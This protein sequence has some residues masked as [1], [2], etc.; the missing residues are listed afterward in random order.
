[1]I[2]N[3]KLGFKMLRHGY[4]MVM[5]I[6]QAIAFLLFGTCFL[7]LEIFS[8]YFRGGI[9]GQVMILCIG[10]LPVQMIYSLSVSNFVLTS[11]LRKKMQT[12]VPAVLAWSCISFLYLGIALLRVFMALKL[13]ERKSGI[14]NELVLLGLVAMAIMLY[15]GIAYKYFVISLIFLFPIIY[16]M[17]Y[18]G[19]WVNMNW[20]V[21]NQ[22][23]A[24]LILAAA[25]GL[26][27]IGLGAFG[28]YL[29][30]LL[31]YKKPM[32]K[33]AQAAPLRKEL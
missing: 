16:C 33:M 4:G 24:S 21:F 17:I 19:M 15:M 30:S 1:M 22:E 2:N 14:C 7:L 26:V 11:P 3:W 9:P 12:S 18:M 10:I 6:V 31:L 8:D 25:I 5:N 27:C 32:S 20:L 28:E 13:P 29:I 23:N